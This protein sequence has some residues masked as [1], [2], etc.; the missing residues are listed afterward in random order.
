LDQHLDKPC[1]NGES[2]TWISGHRPTGFREAV[3]PPSGT[4]TRLNAASWAD[5]ESNIGEN[6]RLVGPPNALNS[7]VGSACP[8]VQG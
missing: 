2:D 6:S 7:Q 8:T 4:L 3:L 5:P 1:R